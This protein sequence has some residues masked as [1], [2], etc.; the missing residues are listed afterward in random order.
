MWSWTW[1]FTPLMFSYSGGMAHEA[2]TFYKWLAELVSLKR[3]ESYSVSMGW[4]RCRLS[5]ALWRSAILWK[6]SINSPTATPLSHSKRGIIS[7]HWPSERGT[8][9]SVICCWIYCILKNSQAVKK[10][11]S[12]V[13]NG[14]HEKKL[15]NTGAIQKSLALESARTL[16]STLAVWW[17]RF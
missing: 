5:S 1:S 10:G 8:A 16:S 11:C 2:T 7:M 15:W 17:V 13:Q 14:Q 9:S 6:C 12:P 3:E 4:L